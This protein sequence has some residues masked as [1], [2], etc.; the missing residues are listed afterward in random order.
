MK[1]ISERSKANAARAINL[2]N[3]LKIK[4]EFKGN[5]LV[6]VAG[7]NGPIHYK[8]FEAKFKPVGAT[9]FKH[10]VFHMVKLCEVGV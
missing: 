2:L 7:K 5:G 6:I 8:A 1:K 3:Q 4:F 9:K 10:G